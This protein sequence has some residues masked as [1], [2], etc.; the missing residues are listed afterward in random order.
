MSEIP[1]W[2]VSGRDPVLAV[3]GELDLAAAVGLGDR[4]A[5]RLGLAVRVHEHAAVDVAG[6]AADR[7]DQARLAAQ[8]ALLVGVEDR[9]QR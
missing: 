6:G 5:H 7:L 2:T 1:F 3:V 4:L 8:E 9:D